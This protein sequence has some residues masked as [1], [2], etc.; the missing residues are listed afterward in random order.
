MLNN[1]KIR[2]KLALLCSAF[3]LP[4][5]FLTYLF[6]VQTQKDVN[7]ASKELEGSSYFETLRVE[8]MSV[9]ATSQANGPTKDIEQAQTA[10]LAMDG[11]KGAIMNAG[12]SASKAADAVHGVL[13][14]PK[15][16]TAD[17]Y[18]AAIDAITDHMAKV[19]DGS[20]L[21]LDPDL[22][23]YYTQDLATLKMP[24]VVSAASRAL[25]ASLPILD[26]ASPSAEAMVAFLTAKG[27]F[28]SALSGLDGDIA[29]GERG[30]PDGSMKANLDA[31]Y[32]G[33]VAKA[34]DFSKLLDALAASDGNHPTKASLSAAQAAFHSSAREFWDVA[35]LET[36]HLLEVRISG[37]DSKMYIS[38]SITL[39]VFLASLGG[40]WWIAGSIANP[41]VG[42]RETMHEMAEGSIDTSVAFTERQ[43]EIG[44]MATNVEVFRKGLVIARDLQKQLKIDAT[45]K[46]ARVKLLNSLTDTFEHDATGIA[47]VVASS[48][49]QMRAAAHS[50]TSVA[51]DAG[52]QTT[53]VATATSDISLGVQTVA[54]AAEE[55]SASITEISRQV[56][57]AEDISKLATEEVERTNVIVSGLTKTADKIGEVVQLINDIASQTNLLALNAT[58]EAAR[59][60]EAGKGFAVVANEV[61]NLA[62]Q[63]A[64]ATDEITAQIAAVQ[65]ETRNA[66][67]AIQRIGGVIDQVRAIS[68]SI[69]T[70][71]DEQ[72]AA[73]MEIAKNAQSVA[74]GSMRVSSG[75]HDV[76]DAVTTT[77]A[78][79]TQVLAAADDLAQNA[80]MLQQHVVDFLSK[81]KEG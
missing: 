52:T 8:L 62:S 41:I 6:I 78:V 55:L 46:D 68:T 63:T 40:A 81:V 80:E 10:V 53:Q 18:D 37:L 12:D 14:L 74:S 60:G 59:A 16:S 47:K 71:V 56:A 34:A 51:H 30:N 79:A 9:I 73:T 23:S 27:T 21:T 38:L 39:V 45:S 44:G 22:D 54:S 57:Q 66:V 49:T 19:E 11:S 5:A 3:L 61:K 25:T 28:A 43:D 77:S 65:G 69:A 29:S 15:D 50:V 24:A 75:I 26:N 20:N 33:L 35:L 72:G 76:T 36:N 64:R 4:I 7:F 1:L 67:D 17:A 31:K 2:Q 42:L 58:I 32:T 13:K 70:S 48:A